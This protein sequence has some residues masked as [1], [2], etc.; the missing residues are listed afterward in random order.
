[1][2]KPPRSAWWRAA[3]LAVLLATSARGEPWVARAFIPSTNNVHG[4][5]RLLRRGDTACFQTILYSRHLRRGLYEIAKEERL[6]WPEGYPCHGDS[7]NYLA[8][9][10]QGRDR[11]LEAADPADTNRLFRLLV[12]CTL[13]PKQGACAAYEIDLAGPPDALQVEN[14]RL[15][16]SQ[17]VHPFYA[18]RAML[19]MGERGFGLT[20]EPL[21]ELLKQAAWRAADAPELPVEQ[22]VVPR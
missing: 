8:V 14:P 4:E 1:V 13:D 22:R 17:A 5:V 21:V 7:T 3:W 16:T 6:S 12:E 19:L 20:G 9:L 18:S 2:T 15:V 10:M 11:V